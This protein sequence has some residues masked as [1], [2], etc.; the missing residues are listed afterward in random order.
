HPSSAVEFVLR[1]FSTVLDWWYSRIVE[2]RPMPSQR[3]QFNVRADDETEA[4]V[5]RLLPLVKQA[6]GID[7]SISDLFRLGMIELERKH[8]GDQ[9]RQETHESEVPR[10]KP[11]RK[12]K[13]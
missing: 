8:G 11:A 5:Q 12:A 1:L 13:R 3:K 6:L 7:V 4:R 10:P 2:D 9:E